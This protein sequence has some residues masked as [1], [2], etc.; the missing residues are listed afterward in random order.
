[1]ALEFVKSQKGK[2]LLVVESCT[3]RS[4]T[5]SIGRLKLSGNAQDI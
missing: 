2:E 4:E 1:M 3:F 5:M